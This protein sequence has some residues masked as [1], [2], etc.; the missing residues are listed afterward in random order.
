MKE[1]KPVWFLFPS[2]AVLLMIQVYPSLYSFFLSLGKM[3]GGLY[4]FVG[5]KNFTALFKTSDFYDSLERTLVFTGSYLILCVAIGMVL[6]LLLN[7]RS[8]LT[9]FYLTC[10]FIPSVISEVVGGTMWRWLFQQSYGIA[11]V[12]LNPL[13]DNYSLLSGSTG[14]MIIVIAASVWQRL[15]FVALIYLG[16]MQTIPHE[17]DE[18]A[19]L[20]GASRWQLFWKITLPII[21]PAVLITVLL[22][23]IRGINALGLIL[24]TTKGGP[25]NATMTTAMYLYRTAWNFGDFG[26]AAALSVIMF[27][28]NITLTIVYLRMFKTD[29]G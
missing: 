25:G 1:K 19:A 22:T 11:Q 20:D 29:H 13:I 15:A 24:A 6:A 7:R 4:T 8:R 2:L 5:L 23:S 12:A 16:A 18:A 10:I 21:R 14:A 3:K 17:L 28:F 26:T 27:F 9:P